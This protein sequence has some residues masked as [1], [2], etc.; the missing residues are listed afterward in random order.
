MEKYQNENLKYSKFILLPKMIFFCVNHRDLQIKERDI[1]LVL[2]ELC[3]SRHNRE[4]HSFIDQCFSYV[5]VIQR[6]R[7]LNR[8]SIIHHFKQAII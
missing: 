4:I 3:V 1:K 6:F 5:S 7:R 2:I 8:E